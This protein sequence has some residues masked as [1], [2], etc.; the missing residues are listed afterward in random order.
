MPGGSLIT[1]LKADL[2]PLE[3][4]LDRALKLIRE[5]HQAAQR[6]STLPFPGVAGGGAVR[7]AAGGGGGGRAGIGAAFRER[8]TEDD[9][10]WAARKANI[11]RGQRDQQSFDQFLQRRNQQEK[12]ELNALLSVKRDAQQRDE[13][14]RRT[15][16]KATVDQ[17]VADQR[18][19]GQDEKKALAE[20][21]AIARAAVDQ[22]IADQRRLGQDEKKALAE[23]RMV[24]KATID[25]M[26]ADQQRLTQDDLKQ[27]QQRQQQRRQILAE[28]TR[29]ARQQMT[30]E[31]RARRE[32]EREVAGLFRPTER[33]AARAFGPLTDAERRRIARLPGGPGG[34]LVDPRGI[35]DAERA[36]RSGLNEAFRS[37]GQIL[38]SLNLAIGV[39][40][41]GGVAGVIAAGFK[42][43]REFDRFSITMGASLG[44]ITDVVDAQGNLVTGQARVNA[45]LAQTPAFFQ[46]IRKIAKDTLLEQNELIE[47][48]TQN[49]TFAQQAGFKV[50]T[51]EQF[52]RTARAIASIAQLAR[53][54]GLPGGQRQLAQEVRALFLGERLQGAQVAQLLGFRS[55]AQIQRLQQQ[56]GL[57][58]A[59]NRFVNELEKRLKDVDPILVRFRNS[60]EGVTTT[61]ISEFKEFLRLATLPAFQRI[62]DFFQGLRDNL[63]D[64][65]AQ[66]GARGL[67]QALGDLVGTLLSVAKSPE[68]ATFFRGLATITRAGVSL[69]A[70]AFRGLGAL[71]TGDVSTAFPT[72]PTFELGEKVTGAGPEEARA[73]A[74]SIQQQAQAQRLRGFARAVRERGE[75][76]R[77]RGGEPTFSQR[78]LRTLPLAPLAPFFPQVAQQAARRAQPTGGM[79]IPPGVT[80]EQFEARAGKLEISARE[81]RERAQKL[82][83]IRLQEREKELSDEA[84]RERAAAQAALA[85]AQQ[86]R[87]SAMVLE[88]ASRAAQIRESVEDEGARRV[89]LKAL[90]L[91]LNRELRELD[92]DQAQSLREAR[93]KAAADELG[94]LRARHARE[95]TE[96]RRQFVNTKDLRERE[97]ALTQQQA[98]ETMALELDQRQ[99]QLGFQAQAAQLRGQSLRDIDLAAKKEVVTLRQALNERKISEQT[100]TAIL[101]DIEVDRQRKKARAIREGNDQAV[102]LVQQFNSLVQRRA[103]LQRGFE[104]GLLALRERM[105]ERERGLARARVQNERELTEAL[106]GQARARED[107][108]LGRE[109]RGIRAGLAAEL[110]QARFRQRAALIGPSGEVLGPFGPPEEMEERVPALRERLQRRFERRTERELPGL[111]RGQVQ[112]LARQRTQEF[113][114]SLIDTLLGPEGLQQAIQQLREAGLGVGGVEQRQLAGLAVRAG[115]LRAGRARLEETR[116]TEDLPLVAEEAAR[117]VTEVQ[118]A[119]TDLEREAAR[120][121]RDEVRERRQLE[122]GLRLGLRETSLEFV[123]LAAATREFLD[124]LRRAGIR[125]APAA[126][127]ALGRTLP[128]EAGRVAA[129]AAV[130][131]ALVPGRVTPTTGLVGPP[132]PAG[133][134]AIFGAQGGAVTGRG[135]S[136]AP[137]A[138][139]GSF[140]TFAPSQFGAPETALGALQQRAMATGIVNVGGEAD[141]II[142][143]LFPSSKGGLAAGEQR[144]ATVIN[145]AG[146]NIGADTRQ[147]LEE[148]AKKLERDARRTPAP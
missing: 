106:R 113:L 14:A 94:E 103:E 107:L 53:A 119:R 7:G 95:L 134:P 127:A 40:M 146:M 54:I 55:A 110:G 63:G 105:V 46:I 96:L 78:L 145:L 30:L 128:G 93:A 58:G 136:I 56:P 45:L 35:R 38:Q 65:A 76:A 13:A 9:R 138:T 48:V 97:T 108:T 84:L 33:A 5:T 77:F 70:G 22:M 57:E 121:R 120:A 130:A 109:E 87:R 85:Q 64:G 50:A 90:R 81:E 18:R 71:T 32:A 43:N 139:R 11:E 141:R 124:V 4:G 52:E 131:G 148:L 80:P 12:R 98:R 117:R 60:F 89:Q 101:T 26:V 27:R 91:T 75:A 140:E 69:Q 21:R 25:Q 100:F 67:G 116:A 137:E 118:Q 37:T 104:E 88:A 23:R 144:A 39:G 135:I 112:Q 3:Q 73:R 115:E 143:Q 122:E 19:L 47:T 132:I 10:F 44:L 16:A 79:I 49:L 72:E 66:R 86:Q 29:D 28:G 142:G 51:P 6:L 99:R 68:V 36:V 41:L 82:A 126:E 34:G 147:V 2:R 114:R 24:A 20:R 17:M 15:A 62:T 129:E 123:R 102:D 31:Q 125:I 74:L 59:P 61:L 42:L 1:E 92:E 133:R 111:E 8:I 83:E